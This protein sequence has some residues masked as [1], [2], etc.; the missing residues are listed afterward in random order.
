[1]NR[2]FLTIFNNEFLF[3]Q[4]YSV[5]R[6]R[7]Q[8]KPSRRAESITNTEV[9]G[10]KLFETPDNEADMDS[11]EVFGHWSYKLLSKD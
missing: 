8:I 1:M 7:I 4:K 2:V 3:R 10:R 5:V 11:I 6:R 9:E